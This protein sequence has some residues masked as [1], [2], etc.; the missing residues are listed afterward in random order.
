LKLAEL[1]SHV[2]EHE[3]KSWSVEDKKV[4]ELGAGRICEIP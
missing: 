4:L 2:D 1:I 3:D